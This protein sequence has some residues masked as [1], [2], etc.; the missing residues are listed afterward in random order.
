MNH[1]IWKQST[2]HYIVVHSTL[3]PCVQ[4]RLSSYISIQILGFY[5]SRLALF[6]DLLRRPSF[7][8]CGKIPL[9]FKRFNVK[10]YTSAAKGCSL[11]VFCFECLVILLLNALSLHAKYLRFVIP[12]LKMRKLRFRDVQQ[13]PKKTQVENGRTQT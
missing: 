3:L 4:S 9:I 1:K 6:C 5:N 10:E 8:N 7:N 12:V 11:L 13:F 2:V